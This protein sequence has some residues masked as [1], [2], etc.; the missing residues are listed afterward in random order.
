M[1]AFL[2]HNL[3]WVGAGVLLCFASSFGQT[4]FIS[5]FAADIRAAAGISI[6][7]WGLV[8]TAATLASAAILLSRGGLADTLPFARLTT[9][10]LVLYAVAAGMMAML[11][12]VWL[13]LAAV[14]LLRF[15]GQG[16]MIHIAMTAMGRWF[17]ARRGRAV[18][19][20]MLG[21]SLGEM[22][23][24]PLVA[25]ALIYF[26]WREIWG[27]VAVALLVVF[28]PLLRRLL[29]QPRRAQHADASEVQS[30]GL[31]GRHWN[32]G[33]MIR[34]SIFTLFV[35][36]VL[37]PGFIGTVVV[38]HQLHL[39]ELR[40]WT[41]IEIAPA[42]SIYAGLTIMAT[43]VSGWASDRF[44]PRRFLPFYLLPMGLGTAVIGIGTGVWA[45]YVGLSLIGF[46]FG[47]NNTLWNTIVPEV[48]G[49][50][51]LGSLRAVFT[52]VMV[53]STAIGPGVTGVLIDA[54][55]GFPAQCLAMGLWCLTLSA[56]YLPLSRRLAP[57]DPRPAGA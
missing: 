31:Q 34:H 2:H 18:S 49:T 27:G 57:A 5:L 23:L 13:L 54:G 48:Y 25:F 44:G 24:P 12:P 29:A 39:A 11:G 37:T 43:L 4:W 14:L 38:F 6:G 36:G 16:M 21:H 26:G 30:P 53:T 40:G 33:E 8:Y 7:G 52:A 46:S 19:L 17:H 3:R 47:M 9:G 56:L 32:R 20:A 41:L 28:M 35:P 51:H 42:F 55:I 22:T 1:I 10:V 45:W 50:R 15:C